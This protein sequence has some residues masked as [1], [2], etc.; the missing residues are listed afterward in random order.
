MPEAGFC[1]HCS[2][3]QEEEIRSDKSSDHTTEQH[4]QPHSETDECNSARKTPESQDKQKV[5][6]E[7][8]EKLDVEERISCTK[9]DEFSFSRP[10]ELSISHKVNNH[11]LEGPQ[12]GD[13][14]ND[15]D[16]LRNIVATSAVE[17]NSVPSEHFDTVE[18]QSE[19]ACESK[20]EPGQSSCVAPQVDQQ[21]TG[22]PQQPPK[23]EDEVESPTKVSGVPEQGDSEES[24]PIT[25]ANNSSLDMDKPPKS[26]DKLESP[27]KVSGVPEQ[28]DSEESQPTTLANNSPLD[29]DRQETAK[30]V[31]QST[32]TE[33]LKQEIESESME[34]H[35]GHSD[36]GSTIT[37]MNATAV[38]EIAG[39]RSGLVSYI[40]LVA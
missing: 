4:Q 25:L 26:E 36:S 8:R 10:D 11:L 14:V 23:P 1:P 15:D 7:E 5:V 29:M 31:G 35:K 12:S 18:N 24:Q 34:T 16:E 28:G 30:V 13:K 39:G 38:S 40:L 27:T 19:S 37:T 17:F 6:G 20:E 2:K 9:Q 21:V 32:I 33:G 22:A 3:S